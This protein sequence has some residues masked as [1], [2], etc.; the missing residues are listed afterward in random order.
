MLYPRLIAM[1]TLNFDFNECNFSEKLMKKKD[2]KGVS[3]EGAGRVAMYRECPG[4][5]HSYT[6]ECNYACGVVLNQIGERYDIEKKKHIVDT[7]AVLD[8]R[9]YQPYL[10]QEDDNILQYRFSGTIF[11]DIGR[12]CMVSILDMIYANP[13]P[14]INSMSAVKADLAY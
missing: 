5:I 1:N 2:K 11:H 3:R 10:F 7:E 8:P 14:R 12:A 13:N 9:T 4:L 6:L